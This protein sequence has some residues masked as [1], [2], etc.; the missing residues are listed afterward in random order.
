MTC[1]GNI[2]T[3]PKFAKNV[4]MIYFVDEIG[5]LS[6]EAWRRVDA[7]HPQI[8]FSRAFLPLSQFLNLALRLR[9]VAHRCKFSALQSFPTH[10]APRNIYKWTA[11][12]TELCR[13]GSSEDRAIQRTYKEVSRFSCQKDRPFLRIDGQFMRSQGH[14]EMIAWKSLR[15]R[16][17]MP[18]REVKTRRLNE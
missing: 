3:W 8:N 6:C 7:T 4:E 13:R 11:G 15:F 1:W 16:R 18:C 5:R 10:P 12:Q 14:A 17:R 2:L 9:W